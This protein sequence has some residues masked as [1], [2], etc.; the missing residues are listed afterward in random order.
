VIVAALNAY[1]HDVKDQHFP[2]E[3]ESYELHPANLRIAKHA[4]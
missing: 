1:D 4:A 2:S 3:S